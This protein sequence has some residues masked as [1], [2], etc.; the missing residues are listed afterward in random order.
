L[1]L[2][3]DADKPPLCQ[4]R[5]TT[6][7]KEGRNESSTSFSTDGLESVNRLK[8]LITRLFRAISSHE[9]PVVLFQDDLQWTDQTGLDVIRTLLQDSQLTNFLFVG[10]YRSNLVQKD[11][12]LQQQLL[13]PIEDMS[14]TQ[15][16]SHSFHVLH[17]QLEGLSAG[18]TR[19][20]VNDALYKDELIDSTLK[21][22]SPLAD[23][24]HTKTQGNAFF[25]LSLLQ[26]LES[27]GVLVFDVNTQSWN[28]D[29]DHIRRN[30]PVSENIVSHVTDSLNELPPGAKLS[31]TLAAFI[32]APFSVNMLELLTE[33]CAESK[34][35]KNSCE[36]TGI[37][38]HRQFLEECTKRGLVLVDSSKDEKFEDLY[39][40]SHDRIRQ[41]SLLLVDEEERAKLGTSAARFLTE[42]GMQG[43][44]ELFYAAADIVNSIPSKFQQCS[45]IEAYDINAL[46]GETAFG[47][48][49]FFAALKYFEHAI[50]HLE[51][52]PG[53]T[54]DC[55]RSRYC[56]IFGRAAYAALS[57]GSFAKAEK[58]A[59]AL[60]NNSPPQ[61]SKALAVSVLAE[62]LGFQNRHDESMKKSIENIQFLDESVRG[63]NNS[64]EMQMNF[65]RVKRKLSLMKEKDF[66]DLPIA[67]DP[68]VKGKIIAFL[69][70]QD[71]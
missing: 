37:I 26:S 38:S 2:G 63:L 30:M 33:L 43:E 61:D 4:A 65:I 71:T 32:P 23:I 13:R 60:L 66:L 8:F 44:D 57:T 52:C 36:S 39:Y 11:G 28:F 34:T 49:A 3:A 40:F 18:A 58:L 22:V 10:T 9:R 6:I 20:L 42:L 31:L 14:R 15:Q 47:A 54:W 21:C 24:I 16:D 45:N 50:A 69:S 48:S 1:E 5:S 51:K 17:W 12:P 46:A 56:H 29:L 41:S 55:Q 53:T 68:V 35:V 19:Q 67:N 25:T 64:M 70:P 59:T 27:K 62:S 7:N